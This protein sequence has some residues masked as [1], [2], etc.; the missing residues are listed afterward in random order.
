[1]RYAITLNDAYFDFGESNFIPKGEVVEIIESY[2]DTKTLVM[3]KG[4]KRYLKNEDFK[5]A[6]VLLTFPNH[7][8]IKK[9]YITDLNICRRLDY[10]LFPK[11]Y[12]DFDDGNL[13]EYKEMCLKVLDDDKKR[14]EGCLKK[15]DNIISEIALIESLLEP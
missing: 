3:Y 11:A 14:L 4:F 12:F 9:E 15:I 8:E 10:N 7:K 6:Y 5:S 13:K 1:M 2:F